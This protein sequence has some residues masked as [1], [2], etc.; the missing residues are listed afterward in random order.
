MIVLQKGKKNLMKSK[1]SSFLAFSGIQMLDE[2]QIKQKN[3]WKLQDFQEKFSSSYITQMVWA[4]RTFQ[5]NL[6]HVYCSITVSNSSLLLSER[7]RTLP[8]SLQDFYDVSLFNMSYIL[9]R[10]ID[11]WALRRKNLGGGNSRRSNRKSL[12]ILSDCVSGLC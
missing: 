9:C 4:S 7:Q 12:Y 1:I 10:K 6:K 3:D 5:A 8:F 2:V 11:H